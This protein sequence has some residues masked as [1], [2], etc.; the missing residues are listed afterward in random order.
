MTRDEILARKPG[1]ELD[2]LIDEKVFGRT[3][4]TV[5]EMQE[6]AELVWVNQPTCRNFLLGFSAWME[7]GVFRWEYAVRPYSTDISV[8]W[9]IV[10]RMRPTHIYEL[11][12]FGRNMHK[13]NQHYAAFHSINKPR[14]YNHQARANTL[15][16]AIC[17]AALLALIEQ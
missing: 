2:V 3:F 9:M 10:E 8:A 6:Y 15:T 11:A 13:G 16:E 5:E 7:M 4:P 17:K 12:D 14:D 1:K